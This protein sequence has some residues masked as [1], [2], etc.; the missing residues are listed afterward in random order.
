MSREDIVNC[1]FFHETNYQL[2][3]DLP[4]CSFNDYKIQMGLDMVPICQKCKYYI[5]KKVAEGVVKD[6]LKNKE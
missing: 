3:R 1:F 2:Y 5:P 6:Y 4:Y